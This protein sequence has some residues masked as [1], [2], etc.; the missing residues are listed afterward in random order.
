VEKSG[1]EALQ[2]ALDVLD[3]MRADVPALR[4]ATVRA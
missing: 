3:R 2:R 1:L 4:P